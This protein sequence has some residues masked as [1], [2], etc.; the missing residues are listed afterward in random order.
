MTIDGYKNRRRPHKL[1]IV[2]VKDDI[3]D[4][5]RMVTEMMGYS[6]A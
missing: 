1:C 5:K 4:S 6:E 3:I 2:Y